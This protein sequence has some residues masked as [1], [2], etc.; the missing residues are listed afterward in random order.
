ML[1]GDNLGIPLLNN[2]KLQALQST[3]PSLMYLFPREPAFDMDRILVETPTNNYTLRNLD[4]LFV[5]AKLPD[6]KEM[7]HDTRD[8]ANKLKAPNVEIWCLYGSG[9]DTPSK[10]IYKDSFDSNKY[11]E[12]YGDGDGTVNLDSLRAC[13][14]FARE[15]E[16]PVYS[17]MFPKVDHISI[18][19]GYD[20]ANFIS[21]QI[22]AEDLIQPYQEI[23]TMQSG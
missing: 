1:Y 16:K 8:I 17:K 22:L 5:A 10:I 13:E 3:F 11:Y 2:Y 19:R 12:L 20:A 15:Q 7:W 23:N 21:T 4:D 9:V 14:Q 18:L 6:Q